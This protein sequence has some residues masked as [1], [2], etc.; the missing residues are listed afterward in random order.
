MSGRRDQDRRVHVQGGRAIR[1]A[2]LVSTLVVGGAERVLATLLYGLRRRG[3][4][5][6]LDCLHAP[7]PIGEEIRAAGIAVRPRLAS[8]PFGRLRLLGYDASSGADPPDVLFTLDHKNALL[9]AALLGA[10][11]RGP[12]RVMASHATG[13]FGRKRNFGFLSR[14][15]LRR[16]DRVVALGSG[17]R[18][19]L[20]RSEDIEADLITVI[21]NGIDL[22]PFSRIGES[23]SEA[24]PADLDLP[25]SD[26]VVTIVAA[27][28]PEKF[29]VM[30]LLA[31]ARVLQR[32]PRTTFLIVGAGP[33][34]SKLRA[35]AD[36]LE[37]GGAVRFLGRRDDVPRLLAASDVLALSS[38]PVVE[39]LPLAIMEGM[40]AGLPV[41]ATRVGS[42]EELVEGEVTGLLV[43]PGDM[44][45]F[46]EALVQ[47]LTDDDWR[48]SAGRA[49]RKRA[50]DS[51]G[52]EAMIDGYE[53]LFITAVEERSADKGVA[54]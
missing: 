15:C 46:T 6:R 13:L 1:I 47:A 3:H 7:G 48:R 50:L 10:R 45:G 18:D 53:R 43:E 22:S 23:K 4:E 14:W 24:P 37:L 5:V 8:G 29:H 21:P 17:H 9:A 49:A 36:E 51:F 19:H 16:Y 27:L 25:E 12:V 39:T 34:E 11:G 52:A 35:L 44:E 2:V 20:C 40:A 54:S 26:K 32:C 33:E 30:F 41:V 42:V 38:K 31:A 28:R